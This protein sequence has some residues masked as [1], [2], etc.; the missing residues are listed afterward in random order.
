MTIQKAAKPGYERGSILGEG[1]FY[2]EFEFVHDHLTQSI[3]TSKLLI[4]SIKHDDQI[5][6]GEFDVKSLLSQSHEG[7]TS[8]EDTITSKPKKDKINSNIYF[9]I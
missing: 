8:I 9:E 7:V 6:D 1:D 3:Q 4:D 2:W 5:F